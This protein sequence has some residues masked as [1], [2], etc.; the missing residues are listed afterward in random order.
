MTRVEDFTN[1]EREVLEEFREVGLLN[2]DRKGLLIDPYM[3]IES[4]SLDELFDYVDH[5]DRD[6]DILPNESNQRGGLRR[7]RIP[8]ITGRFKGRAPNPNA[9]QALASRILFGEKKTYF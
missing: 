6:K 5:E 4:K 1:E 7:R 8:F 9:L 2:I 3:E